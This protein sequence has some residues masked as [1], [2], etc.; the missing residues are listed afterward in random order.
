MN[1]TVQS[2]QQEQPQAANHSLLARLMVVTHFVQKQSMERLAQKRRYGKLSLS[3]AD[4]VSL[5]VE[6][7][8][9]PGELAERLRISKQACSKTLRE[10]EQR[11]L[12][13]RRSHP[14]DSRSSM[15]SLSAK[16]LE[17]LREGV[18]AANDI[19]AQ[20]A[21]TIGATRLHRLLD[22]LDRLLA[23]MSGEQA[24]QTGLENAVAAKAGRRPARLAVV[25][26]K[27]SKL[28]RQELA[29]AMGQ[30]TRPELRPGIG[31]LLGML[32]PEGRRLQQMAAIL[33]VSKQAVAASAAELEAQG[34]VRREEDPQD[35][36]Q[37]V[38]HLSPQ[39]QKL[40][41]EVAGKVAQIEADMRATLGEADFRLLD[42]SMHS[43]YLAITQR[44]DSNRALR[45]RIE[46]LSQ[47]LVAELGVT[48][49]RALALDLMNATRGKR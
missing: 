1:S 24:L 6:R 20:L 4:Y 10:L 25:L 11:G 33:G 18:E 45:T 14:Q 31:Q 8:H 43:F 26:P 22:I 16:G 36:R 28:L 29:V 49:A 23:A 15:L 17:L 44:Y 30:K 35:R 37:I 2:R 40:L 34:Y 27:L 19:Q 47:Q 46:Q 42:E 7:D 3:Y 38:V 41:R 12:T 32:G 21:E 48:G 5:L 9:S 39:G 13:R